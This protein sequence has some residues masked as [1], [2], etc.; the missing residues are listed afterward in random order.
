MKEPAIFV[1]HGPDGDDVFQRGKTLI[2]V[3]GLFTTM[4]APL[5]AALRARRS[6]AVSRQC[7]AC[8]LRGEVSADGESLRFE[9]ENDCAVMDDNLKPLLHAWR[10][11]AGPARGQRIQE[12]L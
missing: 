4:P 6:C 2:V 3:P 5:L 11:D 9:H 8:G 12:N 7:P 1:Q 10:R